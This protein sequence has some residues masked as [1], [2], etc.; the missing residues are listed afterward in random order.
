MNVWDKA[1]LFLKKK[2]KLIFILVFV[3]ALFS[4]YFI[5]RINSS[6]DRVI[7]KL[8]VSLKEG[9]LTSLRKIVLLNGKTVSRDELKPLMKYYS[10]NTQWID[11]IVSSLKNGQDNSVFDIQTSKRIFFNTYKLEL[12]TYNVKVNSNFANGKFTIDN[13]E[14]GKGINDGETVENIIPG[15]YT[16]NGFLESDYGDIKTSKEFILMKNEEVQLNFDAI[17]VNIQSIFKDADVYI[18]D[19]YTGKTV[20]EIGDIGPFK[21]DGS[22]YVCI[23]KD[24]PWG[25]IKSNEEYIK[26]KPVINLNIDMKNDTLNSDLMMTSDKFY[27]SVFNALNNEKKDYIINA[28]NDVKS[29]IYSILEERYFLLKNKYIID[30]INI[31]EDKSEYIYNEGEYNANILVQV[32]YSVEKSLFNLDKNKN[33]KKFFTKLVYDEESDE[34]VVTEVENFGL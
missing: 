17:D 22:S 15:I 27:R 25:T 32:D 21:N 31:M 18:N 9:N 2:F 34:W 33:S 30:S 28:R 5:G 20:E 10:E 3:L 11:D 16:I 23:E 14:N 7:S 4:G 1:F 6:R 29:K 26:D 12:K 24:F 19:E 8:E 13:I